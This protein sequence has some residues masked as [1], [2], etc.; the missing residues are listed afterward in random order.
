MSFRHFKIMDKHR[1]DY[2]PVLSR[3]RLNTYYFLNNPCDDTYL[4][5]PYQ[6]NDWTKRQK[7]PWYSTGVNC[8]ASGCYFPKSSVINVIIRSDYCSFIGL[9]IVLYVELF[10]NPYN[11]MVL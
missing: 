10:C 2:V 9:F 6:K 5:I 7:L 3:P 4:H 11:L 1:R 8:R